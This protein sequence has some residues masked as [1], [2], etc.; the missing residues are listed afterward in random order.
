[1]LLLTIFDLIGTFAFAVYGAYAGLK[2]NLDL[3]GVFVCAFLT[4]VGGGTIREML[5]DQLPFYFHQAE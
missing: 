5:L 3:F 2:K 4:A 1:M